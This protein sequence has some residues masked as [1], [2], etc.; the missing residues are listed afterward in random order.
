MQVNQQIEKNPDFSREWRDCCCHVRLSML[1][2][3]GIMIFFSMANIFLAL[4]SSYLNFADVILWL[5]CGIFAILAVRKI[6]PSFL[7]VTIVIVSI[8]MVFKMAV[9]IFTIIQWI[10]LSKMIRNEHSD[11][12]VPFVAQWMISMIILILLFMALDVWFLIVSLKCR[13]YLI[14]KREYLATCRGSDPI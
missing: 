10:Q 7:V 8:I 14:V 2:A 13:R 5:V 1:V 12:T 11:E 4:F 6:N 3:A 9:I